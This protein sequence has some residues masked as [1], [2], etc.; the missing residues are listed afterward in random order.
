M[1]ARKIKR[2]SVAKASPKVSASAA[3]ATAYFREKMLKKQVKIYAKISFIKDSAPCD[4]AQGSI[5][6]EPSK[7]PFA[8]APTETKKTEGDR[9]KMAYSASGSFSD[10]AKKRREISIKKAH[11]IPKRHIMPKENLIPKEMLSS[12]FSPLF[13]DINWVTAAGMPNRTGVKNTEYTQIAT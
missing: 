1:G 13:L 8:K 11:M 10:K 7:Q 3:P 6:E 2:I 5:F 9:S 12:F 4:T